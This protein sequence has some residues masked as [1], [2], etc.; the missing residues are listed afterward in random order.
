VV[1]AGK[2]QVVKN[3]DVKV[4]METATITGSSDVDGTNNIKNIAAN[5]VMS[6]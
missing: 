2:F 1:G 4:L 6:P 3:P 5:M